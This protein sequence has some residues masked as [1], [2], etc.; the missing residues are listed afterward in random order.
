MRI[1]KDEAFTEPFLSQ[2]TFSCKTKSDCTER[3]YIGIHLDEEVSGKRLL[4]KSQT[5]SSFQDITGVC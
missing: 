4:H 5:V 1:Y 3:V 2:P